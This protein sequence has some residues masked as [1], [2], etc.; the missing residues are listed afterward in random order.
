M[1][2]AIGTDIV[3]IK[4]IRLAHQRTPRL[5]ERVFTGAERSY[6]LARQDPYPSLA[7]RFAAKEAF[8]KCWPQ[9]FGWQDVAVVMQGRKPSLWFAPRL[10]DELTG[11]RA[12]LSLS[13]E[14]EYAL[15]FVVLEQV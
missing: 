4:R 14:R 1:L 13:H 7:A 12:H 9:S 15:A 6:A 2:V 8:Q 5:L 3:D 10:Q 11:L